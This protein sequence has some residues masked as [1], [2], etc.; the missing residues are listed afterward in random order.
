M[1]FILIILASLPMAACV[2]TLGTASSVGT[3]VGGA[4]ASTDQF[5]DLSSSSA[6]FG[7]LGPV[8]YVGMWDGY[9]DDRGNYTG[10]DLTRITLNELNYLDDSFYSIIPRDIRYW[11]P[12][13]RRQ[14]LEARKAFY[15]GL[16]SGIAQFETNFRA[17]ARYLEAGGHY[18]RGILQLGQLSLSYYSEGTRCD[19][20]GDPRQLH[21]LEE[22][23]SCGVMLIN[24]WVSRDKYIASDGN[25]GQGDARYFGASRYWSTLREGRRGRREISAFTRKLSVCR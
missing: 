17:S 13:F 9:V 8:E 25:I 6:G 19:V 22:N 12:A 10:E 4:S 14:S 23:L 20:S 1:R 11:C 24:H 5:S 2:A 3:A 15:L 18:S 21:D 7:P 16:V